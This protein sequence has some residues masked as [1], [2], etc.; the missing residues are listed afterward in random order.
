MKNTLILIICTLVSFHPV[1]SQNDSK[2][3]KAEISI[4]KTVCFGKCPVYKMTIYRDGYVRYEGKRF[5]EKMGVWSKKISRKERKALCKK[6][7]EAN[8]WQYE[9]LYQSDLVDLATT[10]IRF[11]YKDKTKQISGKNN[12]PIPVL[13]L[14]K[15]LVALANSDGWKQI[16]KPKEPSENPKM[17][18]IN[19]ELVVELQPG[20]RSFDWVKKYEAAELEVVTKLAANSPYW[21]VRFNTTKMPAD[22]LMDL[23]NADDDAV[24]V[25][26]NR[27]VD[28]RED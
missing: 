20:V 3:R 4:E 21:V 6:F 18:V 25:S 9:D 15:D 22:K 13:E 24:S 28:K 5:A 10:H 27:K 16:R 8:L 19:N 26:Y 1:F 7:R 17:N 2:E 23:I 14:E 11:T 12:R